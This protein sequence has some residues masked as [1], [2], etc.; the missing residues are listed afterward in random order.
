MAQLVQ[1]VAFW[2]DLFV[3]TLCLYR[4]F[5]GIFKPGLYVRLDKPFTASRVFHFG[6]SE[7]DCVGRGHSFPS[8]GLKNKC[9][10]KRCFLLPVFK[11]LMG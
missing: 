11:C 8:M 6:H 9:L 1:R 3:F 4:R 7:G 2:F 5:G 10:F